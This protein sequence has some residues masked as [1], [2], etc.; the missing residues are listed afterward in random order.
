[1]TNIEQYTDFIGKQVMKKQ[2]P[3]KSGNRIN[4]VKGVINHPILNRPAFVFEEDDSYVE[5]N[6]CRLVNGA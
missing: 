3:F 6:R 4:T 2:K 5:C 1:M